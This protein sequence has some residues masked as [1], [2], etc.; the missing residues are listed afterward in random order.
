MNIQMQKYLTEFVGTFFFLLAAAKKMPIENALPA[1][2]RRVIGV[3][4]L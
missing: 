2:G 1:S 4:T 3:R